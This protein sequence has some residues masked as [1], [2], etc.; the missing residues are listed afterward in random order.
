[1]DMEIDDNDVIIQGDE[2]NEIVRQLNNTI[3]WLELED[4][5]ISVY[6]YNNH[7][8]VQLIDLIN[9][10]LRKPRIPLLPPLNVGDDM[11]NYCRQLINNTLL[12]IENMLNDC[13]NDNLQRLR[14]NA[15]QFYAKINSIYQQRRIISNPPPVRHIP[16]P[17]NAPAI[18]G[19]IFPNNNNNNRI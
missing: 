10:N 19:D 6:P 4:N 8:I 14:D 9:P 7:E 3:S 18:M 5:D 13:R 15:L 16:E 12:L 1:M 17:L 11:R 2:I